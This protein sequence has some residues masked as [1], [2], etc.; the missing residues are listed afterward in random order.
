M[1]STFDHHHSNSKLRADRLNDDRKLVEKITL[2]ST[3]A[4]HE[5]L[6]RYSGLIFNAV[7]RHLF[8]ADNDEIQSLYVDILKALYDKDLLGYKNKAFL[9]TWLIVYSRARVFDYVRKKRGRYRIP[10]EVNNLNE[11]DKRILQLYFVEKLDLAIVAHTLQWEGFEVT[12][13]DIIASFQTIEN[14]LDQRYLK[15]LDDQFKALASGAA[16]IRMMRYLVN[17]RAEYER[18]S[19]GNAPDE[20][21]MQRDAQQMEKRVKDLVAQLPEHEKRII[22]LRFEK[23]LTAREISKRMS[24]KSPR[25]IYSILNRILKKIRIALMSETVE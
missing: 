13:D 2:G 19:L 12:A 9:S 14:K 21:L 1:A 11:L 4:W 18:D 25:H 3:E 10:K 17:L 15:R 7:K 5:F 6:L 8:S 20:L 23:R 24:G 16:S 22:H